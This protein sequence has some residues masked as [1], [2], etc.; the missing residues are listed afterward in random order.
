MTLQTPSNCGKHIATMCKT[1]YFLSGLFFFFFN[2]S[3]QGLSK[4]Q[5][6]KLSVGIRSTVCCYAV[7]TTEICTQ[8]QSVTQ[9]KGT[10]NSISTAT[11][12]TKTCSR[13]NIRPMHF[14]PPI[15]SHLCTILS[16]FL[17]SLCLPFQSQS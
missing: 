2:L 12:I 15:S 1:S 5:C 8:P 7:S 11:F 6:D 3:T 9:E 4:Q 13:G 16:S 17:P 10:S 14:H